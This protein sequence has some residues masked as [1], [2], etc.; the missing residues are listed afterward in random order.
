MTVVADTLYNKEVVT[1]ETFNLGNHEWEVVVL[2][3]GDYW[4]IHIL[5]DFY[6][7]EE[8]NTLYL[9]EPKDCVKEEEF[10]TVKLLC[11]ATEK[12]LWHSTYGIDGNFY[13]FSVR[14]EDTCE[15]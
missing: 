1:K 9:Q 4:D 6:R 3:G 13:S 8:L 10:T 12:F 15:L 11:F 14:V 5:D 2:D 7:Q